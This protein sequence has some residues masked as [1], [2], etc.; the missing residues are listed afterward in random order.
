MISE[1]PLSGAERVPA[2]ISQ[3]FVQVVPSLAVPGLRRLRSVTA[4]QGLDGI[5]VK[6]DPSSG[7]Q[8][9][10]TLIQEEAME[11]TFV[12]K[13]PDSVP[14]QSPTLY[15]TDRDSW[16][17]QGWAVTDPAALAEMN[18]PEGETVVEIPD[19]LVPFFRREG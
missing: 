15:K 3:T 5:S 17:V 1:S 18:I 19:R 7:M 16:L 8:L 9:S 10:A 11:I 14:N 13:D 12:A 2:V 6:A 4:A